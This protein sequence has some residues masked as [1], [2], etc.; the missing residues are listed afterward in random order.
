L[1]LR[2]PARPRG[3][4][5]G[6]VEEFDAG[7]AE[8]GRRPGILIV[9]STTPAAFVTGAEASEALDVADVAV[10][11]TFARSLERLEGHRWPTIALVGGPAL[12][13]GCEVALACDFRIASPAARFGQP[14][15]SA[16]VI[17]D[18]GAHGRLTRLVGLA[19][20]R[21][22][23]LAGARLDARQAQAAGLVDEVADDLTRAARV[24]AQRLTRRSWRALELTKL[25][26]RRP[27]ETTFD[28]VL[29]ALLSDRAH[30]SDDS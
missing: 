4:D 11:T 13:A 26:L 21:R 19:L 22:M 27:A 23:L 24:L 15:L 7:L 14:T 6:L 18:A 20:A 5:R 17:A 28:V 16:G 29:A 30:A 3:L 25:A 12:G 2:P 1:S 10:L 8:A 9:G